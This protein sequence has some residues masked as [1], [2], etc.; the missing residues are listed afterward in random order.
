[1]PEIKVNTSGEVKRSPNLILNE[2]VGTFV[3]GTIK[4]RIENKTYPG[5]FSTLLAVEQ[6]DG[7]TMFYDTEKKE[8]IEVDIVEGDTAFIRES[9]MLARALSGMSTGDKVRIV[10]TGKGKAKKGQRAPFMYDVFKITE[11]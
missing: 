10:Y 7:K 8:E 5:K 3:I 2:K 4:G 9:T 1:M 11:D 6:T